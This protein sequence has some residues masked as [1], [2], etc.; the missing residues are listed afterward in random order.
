M[1]ILLHIPNFNSGEKT[2]TRIDMLPAGMIALSNYLSEQDY[3]NKILHLGIE[4][5]LDEHFDI[6]R[7][8]RENSVDTI[9]CDLH[10]YYQTYSL[11]NILKDIKKSGKNIKVILGGLT[12]TLFSRQI[13]EDISFI[14]FV[15]RGNSELP[16]KLVLDWIY[17]KTKVQL[18]EIPNLSWRDDNTIIENSIGYEYSKN[19]NVN[20]SVMD[21]MIDHETYMNTIGYNYHRKIKEYYHPVLVQFGACD[22]GC[23]SC[24]ANNY[25]LSGFVR[26]NT[27]KRWFDQDI[28]LDNLR[29]LKKSGIEN[30]YLMIFD[31]EN[32]IGLLRSIKKNIDGM[33]ILIE[34]CTIPDEHIIDEIEKTGFGKDIIL[35]CFVFY[36]D[37]DISFRDKLDKYFKTHNFEKY[38]TIALGEPYS[39]KRYY[40]EILSFS[41]N[42]K[43][44]LENIS[45][46]DYIPDPMT[47]YSVSS[48]TFDDISKIYN[49]LKK[50]SGKI[51][52][53]NED[54]E[55]SQLIRKIHQ[56]VR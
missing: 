40:E 13:L 56:E 1:I 12:A 43:D 51:L 42:N 28:I 31:Y 25:S 9:F 35:N 18:D 17:K 19:T 29:K 4:K 54:P 39:E 21:N 16:S 26:K 45:F 44:H 37:F 36:K 30:I 6:T 49:H 22:K 3:Q 5:N 23:Y 10:W 32:L 14:D 27:G 2:N 50:N 8:V 52:W 47:E 11:F 55:I 48:H 20:Y 15:I 7:F 46:Y 53:K 33:K 38:L 34:I 41:E 24:P